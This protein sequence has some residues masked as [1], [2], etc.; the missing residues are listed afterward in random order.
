[1]D[2]AISH[3]GVNEFLSL[4]SLEVTR[5][6][7]TMEVLFSDIPQSAIPAELSEIQDS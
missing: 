6:K 2:R 7:G 1:M 4:K 5:G 3:L